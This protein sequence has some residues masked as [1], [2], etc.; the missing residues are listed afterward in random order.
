M[1]AWYDYNADKVYLR[2][3]I[4]GPVSITAAEA[5][6]SNPTNVV[7]AFGWDNATQ[8]AGQNAQVEVSMDGGATWT[9]YDRSTNNISD[10]LP[11]VTLDLYSS[12]STPVTLTISQDTS[13]AVDAVEDFVNSF[14][15]IVNWINDQYNQQPPKET[16]NTSGSSTTQ[17]AIYHNQ[18]IED[19]LSKMKTMVYQLVPGLSKYSSLPSVGISTGSVGS[20]WYQTMIG[21]ISLD[22]DKLKAALQDDPQQVY[23]LFAND[24]D[25]STGDPNVGKGV[26]QQ[27]D[28]T[29]Y[30]FTEFNGII[31]QYASIQGYI[32]QRL[33]SINSQIEQTARFLKQQQMYYI[34][35]YTAMERMMGGMSGEGSFIASAL[36]QG[37]TQ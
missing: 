10:I 17:G 3:K 27:L 9:T 34:Q 35:Q 24:P 20:G 8:N 7:S 28:S 23:E 32:G 4:G 1:T 21:T 11:G 36:K 30:S 22:K 31:D 6:T 14:N 5:D 37:N 19:V 18:M 12:S 16:Q 13:K 2:S 26:V 25:S 29:L 33:L 15:K